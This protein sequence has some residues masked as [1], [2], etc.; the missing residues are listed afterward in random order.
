MTN[1]PTPPQDRTQG[2]W[3]ARLGVQSPPDVRST[4]PPRRSLLEAP[5]AF[6]R[7]GPNLSAFSLIHDHRCQAKRGNK[8]A[9]SRIHDGEWTKR[10]FLCAFSRKG[11]RGWMTKRDNVRAFSLI[12]DHAREATPEVVTPSW[13]ASTRPLCTSVPPR[14]LA[15]PSSGQVSEPGPPAGPKPRHL[16]WD[17]ARTPRQLSEAG[18]REAR[19]GG[20]G[21]MTTVGVGGPGGV[22]PMTAVRVGVSSA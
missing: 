20:L 10:D 21:T 22:R 19:P 4:V 17:R 16:S 1:L 6:P 9:F 13:D 2:P 11:D 15:C 7:I 18:A 3:K 12:R 8:L 14:A 5:R